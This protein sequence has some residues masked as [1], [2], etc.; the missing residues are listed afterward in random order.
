M[1]I[2]MVKMGSM[3]GGPIVIIYSVHDATL[4]L[5]S[6]DLLCSVIHR[7]LEEAREQKQEGRGQS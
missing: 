3:V 7:E 2:P 1:M 4:D 6:F 5:L